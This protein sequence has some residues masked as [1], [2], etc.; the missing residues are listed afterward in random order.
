MMNDEVGTRND[1]RKTGNRIQKLEGEPGGLQFWLLN[2][3][4]CFPFIVHTSSFLSA[5]HEF[6]EGA[7]ARSGGPGGGVRLFR[8]VP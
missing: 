7:H 1:E 2:S 3:D 8:F 4:S 5:P 6:D